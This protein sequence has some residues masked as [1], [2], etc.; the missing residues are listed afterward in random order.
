M[1]AVRE[2][3]EPAVASAAEEDAT[4]GEDP[5]LPGEVKRLRQWQTSVNAGQALDFRKP[6]GPGKVD[7]EVLEGQVQAVKDA[8]HGHQASIQAALGSPLVKQAVYENSEEGAER[9]ELD[10]MGLTLDRMLAGG[11]AVLLAASS[12]LSTFVPREDN[13]MTLDDSQ[14]D[15]GFPDDDD[16]PKHRTAVRRGSRSSLG[17]TLGIE[18]RLQDIEMMSKQFEGNYK[19]VADVLNEIKGRVQRVQSE[20]AAAFLHRMDWAKGFIMDV[21]DVTAANQFTEDRWIFSEAWGELSNTEDLEALDLWVARILRITRNVRATTGPQPRKVSDEFGQLMEKRIASLFGII[22]LLRKELEARAMSNAALKSEVSSMVAKQQGAEQE[23]KRVAAGEHLNPTGPRMRQKYLEGRVQEL[24]VMISDMEQVNAA[25]AQESGL[26]RSKVAELEGLLQATTKELEVQKGRLLDGG[27]PDAHSALVQKYDTICAGHAR[28][29]MH[30]LRHLFPDLS[31]LLK[32]VVE[33]TIIQSEPGQTAPV[34]T[35]GETWDPTERQLV[36]STSSSILQS[37]DYLRDLLRQDKRGAHL[38]TALGVQQNALM[39]HP[40][41]GSKSPTPAPP[42]DDQLWMPHLQGIAQAYLHGIASMKGAIPAYS[43]ADPRAIQLGHL[44][45][46]VKMAKSLSAPNRMSGAVRESPAVTRKQLAPL[47]RK[48]GL[49]QRPKRGTEGD[50]RLPGLEDV[51]QAP[52]LRKWGQVSEMVVPERKVT[53]RQ[54]T[55][56]LGM[57]AKGRRLR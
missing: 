27:D 56:T 28:N 31:E 24:T 52:S 10:A 48:G 3:H 8:I 39:G 51:W 25:V 38:V 1:A 15:A 12:L 55:D 42:L 33:A 17:G 9:R 29:A 21:I 49:P 32:D 22:Q 20:Q 41:P 57:P 16:E 43:P 11:D 2:V 36:H 5:N 45:K 54:V 30:R 50:S 35:S 14:P 13:T 18:A 34:T 7:P 26:L 19:Q 47:L 6:T 44:Q 37:L 53:A 23:G 4:Y 40:P 46:L